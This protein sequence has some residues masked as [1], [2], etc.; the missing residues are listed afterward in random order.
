MVEREFNRLLEGTS[1][2]SHSLDFNYCNNK[3]VSLGQSLEWIIKLQVSLYK[4]VLVLIVL[5]QGISMSSCCNLHAQFFCQIRN[6][7]QPRPSAMVM[8]L[9]EVWQL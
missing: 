8:L 1:Y 9:A 2:L 6:P 3:P 7:G 5:G 4:N